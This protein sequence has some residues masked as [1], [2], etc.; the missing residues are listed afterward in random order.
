MTVWSDFSDTA[1]SS[2]PAINKDWMNGFK[3]PGLSSMAS[4]SYTA[5]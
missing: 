3:V 1:H 2:T 5:Y 4:R